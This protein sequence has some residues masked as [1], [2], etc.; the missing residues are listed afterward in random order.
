MKK[1]LILL[2]GTLAVLAAVVV[3]RTVLHTPEAQGSADPVVIDLDEDAIAARLAE[4]IRFRTVS[5]Q[6]P[7]EFDAAEGP[8]RLRSPRQRTPAAGLGTP[9]SG[10]RSSW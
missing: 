5:H 1:I 3:V 7:A 2:G 6:S 8:S 9:R 10:T 4:A